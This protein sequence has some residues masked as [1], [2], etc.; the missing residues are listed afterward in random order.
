LFSQLLR[1]IAGIVGRSAPR[2]KL[3]WRALIPVAFVAEA[4]A[5][6]T[7]REPFATMDGVRMAKYRMFF[8]S[9]KAEQQLGYKARP[10]IEGINDAIG[11]FRAAGFLSS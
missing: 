5:N 10:Y 1:D 6:V 3:P 8:E 9:A 11:W 7:G 4:V 2:I